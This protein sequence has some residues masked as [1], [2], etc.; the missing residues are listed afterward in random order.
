MNRNMNRASS[1]ID[2]IITLEWI[3][4]EDTSAWL[5]SIMRHHH[6]LR[7]ARQQAA[8]DNKHNGEPA[9]PRILWG[10][11]RGRWTW[12][13]WGHSTELG[14][15]PDSPFC[16]RWGPTSLASTP[17]QTD[18]LRTHLF[19]LAAGEN[20]DEGGH[21]QWEVERSRHFWKSIKNLRIIV[22]HFGLVDIL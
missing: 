13:A 20:P 7:T 18:N 19:G 6:F 2:I 15:K 11:K 5:G 9:W 8:G 16:S 14:L 17:I 3:R 1:G 4:Y 22:Y 10:A 21:D 12:S